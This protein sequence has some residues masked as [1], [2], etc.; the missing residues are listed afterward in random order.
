MAIR[1]SSLL[2]GVM[3]LL[4]VQLAGADVAVGDD[5]NLPPSLGTAGDKQ[6]VLKASGW[7]SYGPRQFMFFA[8]EK[9]WEE[10]ESTCEEYGAH[11]ASVHSE[12]ED[13]FIKR[14]IYNQAGYNRP[15][16]LGGYNSHMVPQRWYWTDESAFDF[17]PW[18]PGQPDGSGHC[19]QTNFKGGWDDLNCNSKIPFVCARRI[20]KGSV[21]DKQ[22]VLKASGWTSYGPRQFMFFAIEKTWEEAEST[23]EEYG[24]HLASVH[25][26]NEDSF[27]KRLIYNQAGYNRPSWLGGYN[28][29]IVPKRWYWT[30]ESPFDFSPWTPGQ[31]DGSGH[32][33]QNNFKGGWDDLNC[34]SKIPFVCARLIT[35]GEFMFFNS[36][37]GRLC[38]SEICFFFIFKY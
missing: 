28:S 5:L 7:T 38:F 34:N 32:C 10:A 31:P 8:I 29:H 14:L 27:I 30:D 17:S 36:G 19:L 26:E 6:P 4:S 13:S 24:A 37:P 35:K 20:T 22:P 15:S 2:L 12:N 11:L 1:C 3:C 25:S 9:T 33:L 16:W 18:T 21:G 23:C